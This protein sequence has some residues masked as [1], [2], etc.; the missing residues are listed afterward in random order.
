MNFEDD[1]DMLYNIFFKKDYDEIEKTGSVKNV[2]FDKEEYS[3]EFLN[4]PLAKKANKLNPCEIIINQAGNYYRPSNSTISFGVNLSALKFVMD[5]GGINKKI[6]VASEYL[7]ES[8]SNSLKREFKEEIIKGSIHHEL[9]HWVDDTLHNKH[10]SKSLEKGVRNGNF[11]GNKINLHYF[12]IQAI[13]HNI[14]EIKRNHENE[15]NVMSFNDLIKLSPSLYNIMMKLNYDNKNKW[16]KK[17]KR[18]MYREG[19]LGKLMYN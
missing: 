6:N 7:D 4:S 10:I 9:A 8:Q 1:V 18:R 16:I 2:K 11:G 5:N 15:W 3:T 13:I 12:E 19:L 17:I 14:V